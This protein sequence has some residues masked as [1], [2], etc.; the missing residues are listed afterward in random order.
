MCLYPKIIRNPRYRISNNNY[1]CDRVAKDERLEY[2]E[3]LRPNSKK[4]TSEDIDLILSSYSDEEKS[5]KEEQS[6]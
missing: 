1:I 5:L 6:Q 4:I 3:S 2:I